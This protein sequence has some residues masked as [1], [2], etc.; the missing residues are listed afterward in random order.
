MERRITSAGHVWE[1]V[2]Q[3]GAHCFVRRVA[4]VGQP[5][6]ELWDAAITYRWHIS[7]WESIPTAEEVAAGQ[8]DEYPHWGAF[9]PRV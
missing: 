9:V 2:R 7:Q 5:D 6:A 3:D 8:L 1:L 4:I